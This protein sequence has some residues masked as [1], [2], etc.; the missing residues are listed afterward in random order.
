MRF[1]HQRKR[2]ESE[3][4]RLR[5]RKRE[6]ERKRERND[7]KRQRERERKKEAERERKKERKKERKNKRNR[8]KESER[9]GGKAKRQRVSIVRKDYFPRHPATLCHLFL[10]FSWEEEYLFDI[11]PHFH[12]SRFYLSFSRVLNKHFISCIYCR[13]KQ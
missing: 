6:G 8:E 7:R 3:I 10:L 12:P 13:F 9:M 1:W 2:R 11:S 5:K 4:E